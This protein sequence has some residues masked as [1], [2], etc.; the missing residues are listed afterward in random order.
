MLRKWWA[1]N[2]DLHYPLT[3]YAS[4]IS[5]GSTVWGL[6]FIMLGGATDPQASSLVP[7]SWAC[8]I[9][10]G[11][12]CFFLLPEFFLYISLRSTFEQ[13]C[14]QDNRTEIIRRRKEFEDAAE[15]LGSS[16]KSRVLG[17][18]EQMEIKP[19]RRWRVTPSTAISRTKWWS[20]TNSKLS[21]VLPNLQLIKKQSTHQG[22]IVV[23]TISISMLIVEASIGGMDGLTTS[24]NDLILG[25]G[26]A[27]HP[28]PYLD[29]VSGILLTSLTMLLWL[30]SPAPAENEEFD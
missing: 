29:P 19:N 9:L 17:I 30:T 20:N 6:L 27:N 14:S 10:G 3:A 13:I 24:I 8:L 21:R 15:S 22:I 12:G 26:D 11:I 1:D 5:V 18:Y 2:P 7:I 23:T 28:P 4:I 25:T 16:Y